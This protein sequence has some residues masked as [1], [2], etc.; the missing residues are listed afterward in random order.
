MKLDDETRERLREV[1]DRLRAGGAVETCE[2][3]DVRLEGG[4]RGTVVGVHVFKPGVVVARAT[5][6]DRRQALPLFYVV[7][8]GAVA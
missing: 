2:M 5:C 1:I 8:E 6:V 4:K 7:G 3:D